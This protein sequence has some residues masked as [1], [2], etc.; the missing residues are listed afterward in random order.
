MPCAVIAKTEL[1]MEKYVANSL[2]VSCD[3]EAAPK[4]FRGL[5]VIKNCK[6]SYDNVVEKLLRIPEVIR[7]MKAE[8]C[9]PA[10]LEKLR[11]AARELAKKLEG[12]RFA[13]RTVRRGK[14]EFTSMQVNAEL[15]AEV[16]NAVSAKVDLSNPEAVLMVEIVGDEAYLAIVEPEYAGMKKMKGKTSLE[17]LYSKVRVVQEPYLGPFK[18]VNELGRRVGRILQS[19]GVREY[20]VGL[21]EP[22]EGIALAE[23]IRSVH[24]GAASRHKQRLKADG[25]SREVEIK[26]FDIYHIVGSKSNKEVVIIFEPEGKSFEEVVQSLGEAIKKAKRVTLVLGSRKGVPM[27]LYKFADFVVDIA[28]GIVLSTETALAAALEAVGIAYLSSEGSDV[29]PALSLTGAGERGE[30]GGPPRDEQG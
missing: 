15:G 17:K 11:E 3:V 29:G 9:V 5:V 18:A 2:D 24:E 7:I 12:K 20:Y 10:S 14:H 30:G 28:P 22:V 1:G 8:L 27:G 25:R 21:I 19:Y 26:V 13:V 23:F 16:L 4:G 6:E